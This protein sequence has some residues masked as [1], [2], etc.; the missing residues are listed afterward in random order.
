L[1]GRVPVSPR[2]SA[3]AAVRLP[4]GQ[5]SREPEPAGPALVPP[6]ALRA[7]YNPVLLPGSPIPPGGARPTSANG[8][9]LESGPV[10]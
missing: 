10:A 1:V 3:A 2:S 8:T 9:V 7:I 6:T 5:S 4:L